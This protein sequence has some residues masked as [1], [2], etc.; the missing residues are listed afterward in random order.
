M[1]EH[2]TGDIFRSE[3]EALVCPVNVVGVMGA[4]LA[5]AVA[6][7]WPLLV[8][9]Y[10]AACQ[11][12]RL[13]IGAIWTFPVRTG[14]RLVVCFPTKGDWRKPS[15]MEFI[16]AGLLSLVEMI[17]RD[18]IESIAMPALGCGLGGLPWRE[19]EPRIVRALE[20]LS[21]RVEIYAPAARNRLTT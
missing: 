5:L 16:D 13:R 17:A 15:R 21:C 14:P 8:P 19:V 12:R 9:A 4:G 11:T 20:P 7:R 10:Q 3:C 6:K 18:G 2:V 1:I